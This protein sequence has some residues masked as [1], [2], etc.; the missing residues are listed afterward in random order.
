MTALGASKGKVLSLLAKM[1]GGPKKRILTEEQR[2]RFIE[3][4]KAGRDAL[5]IW[6]DQRAQGQDSTQNEAI[7]TQVGE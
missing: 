7:S 1:T 2:A 5:K 3:A 6:R 4:G